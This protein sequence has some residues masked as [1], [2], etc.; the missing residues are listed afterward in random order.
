MH[1]CMLQSPE[2]TDFNGEKGAEV[3]RELVGM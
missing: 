1:G 3:A 2:D